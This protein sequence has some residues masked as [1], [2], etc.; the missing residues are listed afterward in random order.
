MEWLLNHHTLLPGRH[1]VR[2]GLIVLGPESCRATAYDVLLEVRLQSLQI[3]RDE[4]QRSVDRVHSRQHSV[5]PVQ[6]RLGRHRGL[7]ELGE[8]FVWYRPFGTVMSN[9]S[10]AG[11]HVHD[12]RTRSSFSRRPLPAHSGQSLRP[13]TWESSVLLSRIRRHL[14]PRKRGFCWSM[15]RLFRLDQGGLRHQSK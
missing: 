8:V 11:C 5:C 10:G 13:I 3:R 4:E 12:T 15:S 6:H 2:D 14:S 1:S 9:F 7:S